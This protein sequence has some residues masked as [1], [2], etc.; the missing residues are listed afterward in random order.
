MKP[1]L[2]ED[3]RLQPFAADVTASAFERSRCLKLNMRLLGSRG[4][5]RTYLGFKNVVQNEKRSKEA[6]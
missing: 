6:F 1:M 5:L 2:A 3:D 4:V